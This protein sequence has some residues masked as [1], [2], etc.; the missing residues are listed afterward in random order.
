MTEETKNEN[1]SIARQMVFNSGGIEIKNL[2]E[3]KLVAQTFIS[4][5]L[6]PKHF[7]TPAKVIVA[8]QVGREMGFTLMESLMKLHIIN[9]KIGLE[10]KAMKAK[11]LQSGKCKTWK[12]EKIGVA[13]EDSEGYR[14]TVERTDGSGGSVEFTWQEAIVAELI[15]KDAYKKY[16]DDML[17]NRATSKCCRRWFDD[18][19]F[20]VYTD[21]ELRSITTTA[22]YEPTTP[23]RGDR[24][25]TK[26]VE[27][28]TVELVSDTAPVNNAELL[29]K[30]VDAII[31]RIGEKYGIDLD[32]NRFKRVFLEW[33]NITIDFKDLLDENKN[34][35]IPD[36][37]K[38]WPV[39]FCEKFLNIIEDYLLPIP[40]EIEAIFKPTE[41]PT[42]PQVD[43]PPTQPPAKDTSA[44][45][46]ATNEA[47]ST[48][49]APTEPP[50][51]WKCSALGCGA[52][53]DKANY[54]RKGKISTPKCPSCGAIGTIKANP[55][56]QPR[57]AGE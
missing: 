45:P 43:L 21:E 40:T 25:P 26:Q 17:W 5:Q 20:G 15:S 34:A 2:E 32:D 18:I 36:D 27:S 1:T 22:A 31:K 49:N 16:G 33:A 57:E 44:T 41:T 23:K 7:D 48:S 29:Q 39:E 8:I 3:A 42:M 12:E 30:I 55:A 38:T 14:I 9:G 37:P 19:L 51:A 52:T 56:A 50:K 13:G 28:Q 35:T 6:V 24:I 47:E 53:F 54:T 10:A 4:S 46:T 11:A